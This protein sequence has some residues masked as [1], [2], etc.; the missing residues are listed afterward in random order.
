MGGAVVLL[1]LAWP[2]LL[3]AALAVRLDSRGPIFYRQ[4]RVGLSGRTFTL[5][6]FRTMRSDAEADGPRWAT[7]G[8]ARITRV[9]RWLR[10]WRIDELPQL[11]NV[12]AGDMAL[13]GPRP[14]RPEFV[15]K[16]KQ[17]I[18]FYGLREC[19]PP[20][21]SG[22]AQVRCSY[23]SSIEEQSIKLEHDLYYVRHRSLLLDLAVLARTLKVVVL[24]RGAR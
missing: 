4:E 9:G 14:E 10:R 12:L 5:L 21:L 22:W 17:A 2:L 24:G 18:P 16:L 20:G 23:A 6:K 19:V 8:D 15:R 3:L 1:A 11:F 13:V 7:V